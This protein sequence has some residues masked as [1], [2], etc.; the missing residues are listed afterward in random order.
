[1]RSFKTRK[2]RQYLVQRWTK[3][4][5]RDD[6][7]QHSF[8]YVDMYN[9][10]NWY[11]E[12]KIPKARF[13]KFC[14]VFMAE[15]SLLWLL[16]PEYDLK[17]PNRIGMFGIRK[18]HESD[19]FKT[20]GP[21]IVRFNKNYKYKK[22]P[23]FSM[24]GWF[25]RAVGNIRTPHAYFKN[26]HFYTIKPTQILNTRLKIVIKRLKAKHKEILVPEI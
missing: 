26:Q 20:E 18:Y 2:E 19:A 25:Y 3:D 4:R 12:E 16:H 21:Y 23:V 17:F 8:T 24:D 10:Y 14:S 13:G 9:F 15:L 5:I 22:L 6:K 1:M 7:I 11:Q